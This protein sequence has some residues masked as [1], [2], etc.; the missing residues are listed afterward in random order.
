VIGW[1]PHCPEPPDWRVDWPA[2][3]ASYP[4]V[5]A[6]VGCPQDPVYHAEGDVWT[7][8]R[9]VCEAVADMPAFRT[10][11]PAERAILFAAALLHDVAKP[12]CTRQEAGGRITARGHSRR[13]AIEARTI[14]WR[15]RAPLADREQVAALVR[16]HQAPFFLIDRPDSRRLAITISQTA[17]CDLLALLAEADARGRVCGDAARLLDNV[18]LFEEYSRE[19]GCLTAP[20]PFPSDQARFLYFRG[21]GRDPAYE[22]Y[23]DT[24][25]EVALMSG[26]PGAGKDHWLRGHLADRPV[27]ALDAI[28]AE[29]G[30]APADEQGP[31]VARARELARGYL[32]AGESFAWNG[33]NLS[34]ELRDRS[35]GL[36]AAYRA[37]VRI[38]YLEAPEARLLRQNRERPAPVPE[39][40]VERLLSRWEVPDRTE[41]HRVDWVVERVTSDE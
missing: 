18:A 11:P 40:I 14:L 22:A 28:R 7:H 20:Y 16:H 19:Q 41:A 5:R 13:G 37:R 35:I 25:C 2:I 10:L 26:L 17:R 36:F 6:L 29:L 39:A 30:I 21:P 32:R 31:V 12:G 1:F 24:R 4:W 8:T 34:R 15:L 23:D 3:D 33:T 9:L 27:I 38:V